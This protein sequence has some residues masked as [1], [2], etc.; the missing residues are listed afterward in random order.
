MATDRLTVAISGASGALGQALLRQWHQ[1]GARLVA[2]S[3]RSAP[4]ELS[5][6]AGNPIPLQHVPWQVGQ[7]Q[8]LIEQ[9][10]DVDILVLNHGINRQSERSAAAAALSLEVNALSSW[11]LLEGFAALVGQRSSSELASRPHP[12]IWINTSEA[13]IEPAFSPLYE[14]SKRLLGQ[15]LSLRSLD[16]GRQVRLRRLVLGPFRSSLNPV[17]LM[18]A[19]FV[20]GQILLQARLGC[21]LIIITPNPLI[22]V[23]MPLTTLGRWLYNRALTRS[24]A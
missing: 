18:G 10:A 13:E 7:E 2:L 9:L 20:A 17:G 15:L 4:L 12:E 11:R 22:Y 1:Q 19:D 16:L 24:D 5:D 21:N 14:I 3:H 6:T 8:S 23:L